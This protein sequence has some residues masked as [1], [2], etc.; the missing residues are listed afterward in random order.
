[1]EKSFWDERWSQGQIGF[2]LADAN[3][4]LVAHV[5]KLGTAGRVLVPLCGKTL[6]MS[7]LVAAGFDVVGIEFVEVAARSYFAEAGVQPLRV[8]QDGFV[9]YHHGK[10]TIWVADVLMITPQVIGHVD[11]IYDRAAVV[12]LP[13]D[14]RT[15][16]GSKL[17]SF[18]QAGARLL[19][20][21]FEHDLAS[22]PPFSVDPED[23]QRLFGASFSL[24]LV[25]RVNTID[26]S[27]R[28]KE[29]G[30]TRVAEA[31]WFG[32]RA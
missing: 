12:A 20:V 13:E 1:M 4:R 11:A 28:W 10:V 8:E 16:Y 30:A 27:S 31:V 21:S 25:E 7:F 6:D 32:V 19:L 2:H 23:V 5:S 26:E 15:Q 14:L 29:R 22:G 24:G 3:P 9:G 17:A 18:C